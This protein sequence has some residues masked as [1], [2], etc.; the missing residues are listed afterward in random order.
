MVE[1]AHVC[2]RRN[3]CTIL[4]DLLSQVSSYLQE[5]LTIWSVSFPLQL[6]PQCSWYSL[7]K[8][9]IAQVHRLP[10]TSAYPSLSILSSVLPIFLLSYWSPLSWV[11]CPLR[12]C[13]FKCVWKKKNAYRDKARACFCVAILVLPQGGSVASCRSSGLGFCF[14]LQLKTAFIF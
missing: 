14:A 13:G 4:N 3:L 5:L 9:L 12:A 1:G 8:L 7:H 11:V 2:W 10:V 6:P